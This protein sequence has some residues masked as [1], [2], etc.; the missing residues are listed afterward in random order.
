MH[1]EQRIA[2]RRQPRTLE[3]R[4]GQPILE[5]VRRGLIQRQADQLPQPTLRNAFGGGINRRE[6]IFRRFGGR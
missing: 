3:H 6:M 4:G 2:Q 5:V 1:V